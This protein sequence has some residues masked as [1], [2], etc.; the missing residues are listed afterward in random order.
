MGK[1]TGDQTMKKTILIAA[2]LLTTASTM[3]LAENSANAPPKA[4]TNVQSDGANLRQ[5]LTNDL[6]QSGFKNVKVVPGSFFVQANDKTGNPVTMF[7]TS[8]SMSE[9]TTVGS[10]T[11]AA[12]SFTSIPA[13]ADLSSK[14]VGLEVQN[15]ANQNIGTIKDIAFN[16]SEIDGYILSVGGFLGMGDHYVAVRPG[17]LDISYNSSDSKWHAK[18]NATADQLKG[19]PEYKYPNKG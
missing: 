3:A 10:N 13:K 19:A 6:Q 11:Q 12:G 17:A 2:A 9:V 1:Q 14:A 16:G 7:I 8:N 4:A 15:A 18:M 5:Q